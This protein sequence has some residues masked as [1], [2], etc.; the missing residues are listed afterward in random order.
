[1]SASKKK[2]TAILG[3]ALGGALLVAGG[4][5]RPAQAMGGHAHGD[6]TVVAASHR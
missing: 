5:C 6:S 2:L 4:G 3:A 1:M